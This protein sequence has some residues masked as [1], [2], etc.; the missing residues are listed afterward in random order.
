MEEIRIIYITLQ[1][2]F[3]EM[4]YVIR[5]NCLPFVLLLLSET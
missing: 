3:F 5:D 1:S 4:S 2:N